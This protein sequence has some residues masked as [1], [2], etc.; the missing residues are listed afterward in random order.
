MA[1]V[2]PSDLIKASVVDISKFTGTVPKCIYVD[3]NILYFLGY[4]DFASLAMSGGRAPIQYQTQLYPRWWSF[5]EK[6][7]VQFCTIASILDE[8]AHLIERTELD[9]C[10]RTDPLRPELDPSCPGQDF[11]PK[12]VKKVRYHYSMQLGPIRRKVET[13]LTS[14][15]KRM[16]V[17]PFSGKGIQS[18]ENALTCWLDSA[19]DFADASLVAAAK[20]MASPHILSDDADL[21]TFAHIT[22]YTANRSAIAGAATVG[23]LIC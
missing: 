13:I 3:T 16:N 19:S 23:K 15:K 17:L 8:L 1:V 7:N 2:I 6:R 5:A 20:L 12:Y 10:W 4:P 14:I 18:H 9:I 11:S 21:S 22:L